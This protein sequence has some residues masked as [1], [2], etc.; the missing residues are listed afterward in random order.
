[1]SSLSENPK[2]LLHPRQYYIIFN[3]KILK[4][5]LKYKESLLKRINRL[6]QKTM[7]SENKLIR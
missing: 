6:S 5:D 7:A 3:I 1:M 4:R 2:I